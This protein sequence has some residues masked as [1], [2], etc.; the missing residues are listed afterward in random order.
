[1]AIPIADAGGPYLHVYGWLGNT[2]TLDGSGSLDPDGSPID[3]Y[4]WTLVSR[5]D[6]S[7]AALVDPTTV[8]PTLTPDLPGTYLAFLRVQSGGEW[9]E[10]FGPAAP[11]S[12]YGL[13]VVTT[14][15]RALRVP[16][17][18]ERDWSIPVQ[19]ALAALDALGGAHDAHAARHQPGGADAIPVAAP[20]DVGT[21]TAA[22]AEGASTSLAR[23]DHAHLFRL[24]SS[25]GAARPAAAA[26][27]RLHFTSDD[28][29][30]R[31][32][33]DS[34]GA[35]EPVAPGLVHASHHAP[36]A[37]DPVATAAPGSVATETAAPAEG[38]AVTLARADH[39]HTFALAASDTAGRSAASL[40][41]RL[42]FTTDID[43]GQ[44]HRD[45]GAAWAP[46]APGLTHAADH[47][48]G[49]GDAIPVAAPTNVETTTAANT[50]GT[51]T[52]LA[53]ADHAHRFKL[54]TSNTAGR[55]AVASGGC[56][57]FTTDIDGGQ[58]HH[59]TGAAW[60]PV[61]PGLAHKGA[62]AAG[63]SD[64]LTVDAASAPTIAA[65]TVQHCDTFVDLISDNT[66]VHLQGPAGPGGIPAATVLQAAFS[67]VL[68]PDQPRN[69]YVEH[70]EDLSGSPQ[71]LVVHGWDAKRMFPLSETFTL[72]AA[73]TQEG[74][75]AFSE[76]TS[77]EFPAISNTY[78]IA[79][80]LASKLGL[81]NAIAA[82]A[83]Y[84]ITHNGAHVDLSTVTI[85][86]T[87]PTVYV[88]KIVAH[89][90]VTVRYQ[91]NHSHTQGGHAHT[92]S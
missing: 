34:G 62:H 30:G 79:V 43:G 25:L 2:E 84:K 78:F 88:A 57:H 35:W 80:S 20:T 32:N 63:G 59:D 5:P 71:S 86:L 10:A 3:A 45:G 65:A 47:Q 69:L 16:A 68:S 28:E 75:V 64:A 12:A 85:D 36:G 61:A 27:G 60:E 87:E 1:M 42:H 39:G 89:D 48:P 52:S 29:G 38:A 31:L 14:Q 74:T 66:A 67:G 8:N 23:A 54:A 83:V 33:R 55:P 81:V 91:V 4:D 90:T 6:G 70:T 26:A 77:I 24:A 11:S 82:G 18:G 46:V 76:V 21:T 72:G 15:Y 51:S 53:R 58:L 40:A 41:G 19:A 92:L 9:S 22:N 50:E 17:A 56:L 49:G 13:V 37:S 44:L 73:G 7:A